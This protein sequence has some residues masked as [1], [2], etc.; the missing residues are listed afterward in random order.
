MLGSFDD[1]MAAK[2]R[3]AELEAEEDSEPEF[4]IK[5]EEPERTERLEKKKKSFF[6]G[7]KK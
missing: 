7:R 4:S 1:M 2:Y 5:D 6:F 3:Q